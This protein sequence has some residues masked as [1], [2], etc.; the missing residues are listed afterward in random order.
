MKKILMQFVFLGAVMAVFPVKAEGDIFKKIGPWVQGLYHHADQ[1]ETVSHRGF[2]VDTWGAMVGVG[3]KL[4]G[5]MTVGVGYT[6]ADTSVDSNGRD[7]GVKGHNVFLYGE[8]QPNE[9]YAN[10]M[11]N[12]GY[13]RYHEKD[14][15][16]AKYH[17]NSYAASVQSG[18]RFDFGFSPE[19][20]MSYVFGKQS[21]Y[22]FAGQSVH[23][24]RNEL[25]TGRLGM[26]YLKEF[27][28]DEV[29]FVPSAYAGLTYDFISDNSRANIEIVRGNNYQ[30]IG[31]RLHR[32]GGEAGAGITLSLKQFDLSINYLGAYRQHF[33]S[34]AG[35]LKA[36][37]NF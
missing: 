3:A 37:Y 25:L 19:W 15:E 7:F 24:D 4:S 14:F 29:K 22:S 21:S 27:T 31:R 26:R 36:T 30:V 17:V 28:V 10:W 33:Q 35:L 6:Y 16:K 5:A 9:W 18:Y 8:Y 13:N 32:F 2:Q 23:S 1:E 34:H 11:M 12:Y 20:G